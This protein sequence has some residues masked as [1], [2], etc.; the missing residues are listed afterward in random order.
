MSVRLR[1]QRFGA[2]KDP[3]YRLVA[4]PRHKA[5][6]GRFLEILG[7]YNPTAEPDEVKL[8]SERVEYWLS[9]G[10]EPTDTVRSLVRRMRRGEVI[11]LDSEEAVA[12]PGDG[13]SEVRAEAP[14]A[15]S[16]QQASE[17]EAKQ[18]ESSEA[19]EPESEK[20]AEAEQVEASADESEKEASEQTETEQPEKEA[21]A[22]D[23]DGEQK[24]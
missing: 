10:A 13:E 5:R 4:I 22:D 16:E 12:E 2:A 18:A 6:N 21:E 14:E 23:S 3:Y 11:D 1:L 19:D 17:P 20:D 24:E 9:V 7:T 8:H 15:E